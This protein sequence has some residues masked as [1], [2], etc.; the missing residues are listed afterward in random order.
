MPGPSE[1]AVLLLGRWRVHDRVGLERRLGLAVHV[2]RVVPAVTLKRVAVGVPDHVTPTPK[3]HI[4][5]FFRPVRLPMIAAVEKAV[6][7]VWF[8]FRL[9]SQYCSRIASAITSHRYAV[10]R[11]FQVLC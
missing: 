8:L 2:W 1:S 7:L 4:S 11:A 3:T 6:F 5:P 10:P 9:P